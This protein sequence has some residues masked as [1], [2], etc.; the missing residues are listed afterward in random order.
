MSAPLSTRTKVVAPV[1]RPNVTCALPGC[2]N[3]MYRR[4]STLAMNAKAYCSR[5]CRNRAHPLK[6]GSNFPPPKFGAAN[7][8]WKGGVT[9]MRSHG[10]RD[11]DPLNNA[12]PNLELWPTNRDHKLGE[13]GRFVDGVA[14]LWCPTALGRR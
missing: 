8:A 4:P 1:R 9:I 11:H 13:H 3:R 12:P 7:P 10:N 5:A 6:D 2:A 14:N